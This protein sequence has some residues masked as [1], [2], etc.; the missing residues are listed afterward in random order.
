MNE[1]QILVSINCITYNHREYI[2]QCLEGMLMQKTDFKFE[3]LIHDD[4]SI[5]GTDVVL[6]EYAEKYGD[7]IRPI[8]Q[9]ENQYSKGVDIWNTYQFPRA[10]GKYIAIC[11]GDDYWTDPLKLQKQVDFM[12]KNGQYAFC[13]HR[14]S[15]F[16]QELKSWNADYIASIEPP[17]GDLVI[18]KELFFR[19]WV[20]HPLTALIRKE[21]Y[22]RIAPALKK[23]RLQR[24]VHLFYHLLQTGNGF[25]L[26]EDMGVYRVHQGGIASKKKEYEKLRTGYLIYKELYLQNLTDFTL[27]KHYLYYGVVYRIT[28]MKNR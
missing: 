21:C 15:I 18:T 23:Y 7:I 5:D 2:V 16:D 9:T 25:L 24:D 4:A 8:L 10:R 1:E 17:K 12:E 6:R 28:K 3:I 19:I 27:L 13:C 26:N 11:E 20:T 22:D 14:F